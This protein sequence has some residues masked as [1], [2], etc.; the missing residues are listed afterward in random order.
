MP[1]ELK[2]TLSDTGQITISG[3]IDNTLLC[4]GLLEQAKD[5]LRTRVAARG[6]QRIVQPGP[7]DVVALNRGN[8][9]LKEGI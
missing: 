8:G 5:I 2:I 3:P 9:A 7:A 6:A 4:Y 1:M